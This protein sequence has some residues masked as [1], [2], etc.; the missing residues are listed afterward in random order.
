MDWMLEG[1]LQ[2]TQF[3]T[4]Y[5]RK[6]ET[7]R[8]EYHLRKIDIDILYFLFKSGEQIGRASCR[9]RV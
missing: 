6:I 9:E 2:G 7:L 1:L 5:N 3:Q 8:E 4:L